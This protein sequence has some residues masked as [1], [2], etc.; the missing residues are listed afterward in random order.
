MKTYP[1]ID[2][3]VTTTTIKQPLKFLTSSQITMLDEALAELGE[4]GE[5]H[6]VIDKGRLR[7]LVIQKS[8]DANKWN[9]S[10][11]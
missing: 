6:L 2:N 7:F 11:L 10:D 4:Y 3:T 1:P 5:L 8:Y 9:S